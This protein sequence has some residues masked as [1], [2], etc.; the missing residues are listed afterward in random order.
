MD[1]IELAYSGIARQAALIAAGEVSA[2]ELLETYLERIERYGPSLNAFRIVFAERARME[3]GQAEARR[4]AGDVRPLLGVPI[5]IKDDV[6]VAGEVTA[7]GSNA[8]GGPA[9]ADAEVVRR[10]R[11]AGAVILGK[12]N[13]PELCVWPFTETATF[14]ATR[15]PW[16]LQRAPGGSSGGSGAA[17]AAGLVGGALGSDGAG[18]IRIPAAWC[19]LFG[20]KPQRGRVSMAPRA[21]AWNGL[22]VNGI[23][24]RHVA[25]TALFHDVASGTIDADADHAPAP[26][27]TFAQAAAERPGKLRIAFSR[28]VPPGII[29]KL[30]GDGARAF[31]QTI[32][33]LRS[34]GHELEEHDPDYG[35]GGA[36]MLIPRY[37]RGVYEDARG[38]AHPERLE[39][40]TK[41][42]A[43]IGSLAGP[44]FE[45]AMAEELEYTRRLNRIFESHDVL[46]TP[47]TAVGP[48][49]IGRLQ[50]RGALWTL[51]AVAGW[52]PYNGIW[53]VTGQPAA[54][55]PAGFGE[56][57][58]PRSV[59]IVGRAGD[60]LTLLSLAAQLE[61]ERPWAAARPPEFS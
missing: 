37:V 43:R 26:E 20:L 19:G 25:D 59:Q 55:V 31:E 56:D 39:R 11:A 60:E 18:S 15:N 57:G 30:D 13:V 44:F 35:I 7:L 4:S 8:H 6:D 47:A 1:A 16:D 27:T 45:R 46:L 17:V 24:A 29:A 42:M 2:S 22:S 61:A 58:M 36:T 48:P 52:V 12:T 32:E 53:N 28:R 34:L 54:A 14:G 51:N 38:M 41:G 9:A 50:G 23:L 33:L 10:L 5:A 3:A 40:R 21:R 49:R